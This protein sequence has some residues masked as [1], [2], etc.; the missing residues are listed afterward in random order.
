M[1]LFSRRKTARPLIQIGEVQ[2]PTTEPGP[3]VRT[4]FECDAQWKSLLGELKDSG[5][6]ERYAAQGECRIYASWDQVVGLT[7][8]SCARSRCM[9]HAGP[10]TTT[11]EV[12]Q[13]DDYR[14]L[15][16][17]THMDLA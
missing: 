13:A 4:C 16:C 12:P 5:D 17:H 10:P 14:C 1:G 3:G 7:C 9:R 6:L 15:N 11:A 2:E 8:P